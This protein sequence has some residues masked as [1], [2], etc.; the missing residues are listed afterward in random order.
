MMIRQA[1]LDDLEVIYKMLR[2]YKAVSDLLAHHFMNE[3]AV[4]K[5]V[6]VIIEQKRGLILLSED[7]GQ[8]TGMLMGIFSF[9]VWDRDIRCMNDLAYWVCPEY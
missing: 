1:T 7:K 4:Q 2:E 5:G 9:N 8:V 6:E 3:A